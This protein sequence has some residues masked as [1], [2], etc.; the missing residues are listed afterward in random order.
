MMNATSMQEATPASR[1]PAYPPSWI[2]RLTDWI[3][4][5]PGPAWFVY[6][7]AWMLLFSIESMLKWSD[8]SYSPGTLSFYHAVY[9]GF[10]IFAIALMHDLDRRAGTALQAF[11]PA[12][13]TGDAE[14]AAIYYRF[15]TLPARPTL[16][17]GLGGVLVA[18]FTI[19]AM[20]ANLQTLNIARPSLP[21]IFD[22]AIF[23]FI[24]WC[25]GTLIYHTIHQLRLVNRIYTQDTRISAFHLGP[26]YIFSG[27]AART[28][29]GLALVNY[30]WFIAAPWMVA[31][32]V[33]LVIAA[34][35]SAIAA[36]TFVLPL[37]GVH[38]RL[39]QEK[40]RLQDEA[41]GRTEAIIDELHRRLDHGERETLSGIQ[42]ALACLKDEEARLTQLPTWPWQP[43][44]VRLLATAIVLPVTLSLVQKLLEHLVQ[45]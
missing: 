4:H 31:Q 38:R 40:R 25:F 45:F 20:Y 28:A 34:C 21:G 7:V 39:E 41:A 2:N 11:R 16:L 19:I 23:I 30:P 10:G 33:S 15:V 14:Y 6:L 9:T 43:D 3:D 22:G 27:L 1:L 32:P 17:A 36:V 35:F 44:M 12:L 24:W 37:V 26:L 5:L 18:V 8:G 29:L 42:T 13:T